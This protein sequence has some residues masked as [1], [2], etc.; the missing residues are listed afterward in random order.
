MVLASSI[1]YC[2]HCSFD[3]ETDVAVSDGDVHARQLDGRALLG[4]WVVARRQ[5]G[6]VMSRLGS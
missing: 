5:L 1:S 3:G 6:W 4:N 2:Q